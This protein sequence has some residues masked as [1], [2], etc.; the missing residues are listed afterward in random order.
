[1]MPIGSTRKILCRLAV[2]LTV[3]SLCAVAVW[4]DQPLLDGGAGN[5]GLDP[6][7]MP[8]AGPQP[9]QAIQSGTCPNMPGLS[10]TCCPDY[11]CPAIHPG[12]YFDAEAT[13]L[14]RDVRGRIDVAAIEAVP[15]GT[16]EHVLSTHD[17]QEPM[18]A[19]P[20]LTIGHTFKDIP[21]QVEFSYLRLEDFNETAARRSL[22][23]NDF[24]SVFTGFGRPAP[25]FGFDQFDAAQIH[26]ISTFETF[27]LN[28]K[29]IVP[30]V[31]SCMTTTLMVGLR[32]VRID[33]QFDYSSDA[34]FAGPFPVAGPFVSAVARN[35]MW[36]PQI[37]AK[38]EFFVYK[39]TWIN[40]EMK[41]AVLSNSIY[42]E[43][44]G[45]LYGVL[46][47]SQSL[48]ATE[49]AFLGDLSVMAIIRFTPH[50]TTKIGYQAYFLNHVAV[51][52]RN[53]AVPP[54]RLINGPAY[55]DAAGDV[56]YH[57]PRAG[58][59]ITW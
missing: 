25:V 42:R 41:G 58:L 57:G 46:P 36:G 38:G 59:E 34:T 12:W 44:S 20:L 47:I 56:I 1:M 32:H 15:A 39:N 49:T 55:L 29:Y 51:A 26:E 10:C 8:D 45:V 27:E 54:E 3:W 52:S 13:A 6:I 24:V 22:G 37:G 16:G 30:M 17:L 2:A 23:T 48:N 18:R 19:G 33:E 4:A 5:L 50:I 28:F 11:C 7:P 14:R 35:R 9:M 31:P 40:A 53:L 21:W 43:T